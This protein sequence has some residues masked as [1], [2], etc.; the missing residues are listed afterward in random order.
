MVLRLPPRGAKTV[1]MTTLALYFALAAVVS[2]LYANF[3]S[4]EPAEASVFGLAWP[5][6]LALLLLVLVAGV[7]LFIFDVVSWLLSR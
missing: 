5:L 1:P 4:D 6:S 7:A 2:M 3:I